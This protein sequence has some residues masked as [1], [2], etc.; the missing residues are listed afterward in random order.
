MLSEVGVKKLSMQIKI[1]KKLDNFTLDVSLDVAQETVGFLGESGCGKSLTL[2]CIAGVETPD[3]GKIVVNGRTYFDSEAGIN[4]S[5]QDR[6]CALL[7]QD[8]MLFP[9]MTVAQNIAAGIDTRLDVNARDEVLRSEIARLGLEGFEN[10][11]PAQ[12]SGGQKQRVA[13]ARMLAA[14]SE[15]LMLDEPFSA[16][17]SHLKG[18]LEQN[19][20]RVFDDFKGSI[21]YVSHDIDEALFFC[22]RIAIVQD[23]K[24]VEYSS[25]NLLVSHPKTKAAIKLSGCKNAPSAF[26]VSKT[27]VYV[28]KWGVSLSTADEVPKDLKYIGIRATYL[29]LRDSTGEASHKE[30]VF[31]MRIDRVSKSRFL[32]HILLSFSESDLSEQECANQDLNDMKYL[33]RRVSWKVNASEFKD[34][35]VPCVGDEVYVHIP[36][37]KIYMATM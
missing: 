6:K 23:G 16:L 31:K 33:H 13:L 37:D 10:R 4:L 17:D 7:F 34:G 1:K 14:K 22:D 25:A 11:Y 18:V 28:P 36:P 5:P 32:L 24:I 27:E 12:L 26:Y 9:N 30:N 3:E 15:I 8:Y 19:L 29:Q 35:R 20:S 2:K 21:L